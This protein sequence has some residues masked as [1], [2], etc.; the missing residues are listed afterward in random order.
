MKKM[1]IMA[2]GLV[3][4]LIIALPVSAMLLMAAEDDAGK[5]AYDKSC[6]KCH[7]PDGKGDTKMGK[8]IKTPDLTDKASWKEGTSQ[9]AL[10]KVIRE[11]SGK[12]PKFEGKM[13]DAEVSAA[14]A[15][16]IKLCGVNE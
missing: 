9:E 16:T 11:G 13:S 15:Y 2:H 3:M 14:A 5:A 6:G 1:K 4:A 12:M 8:M 10:E 7:G